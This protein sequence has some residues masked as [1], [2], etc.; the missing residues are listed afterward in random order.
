[1][2][3]DKEREV[4]AAMCRNDLSQNRAAKDIYVARGTVEYHIKKVREKTGL[5]CRHFMDAVRLLSMI[6]KE[7]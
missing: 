7:R 5:D 6:N 3:S 1:M 2:F 4:I